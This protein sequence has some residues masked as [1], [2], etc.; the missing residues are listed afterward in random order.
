MRRRYRWSP[1][2]GCLVEIGNETREFGVM[3]MPDIEPFVSPIDQSVVSGRAALREHNKRHGVTNA[4]DYTNEWKQKAAERARF[5]TG[6][7][8]YDRADRIDALKHA[9]EKHTRRK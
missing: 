4:A 9:Y 6:D 8:T 5:F 7:P 1:E 3:V 2:A